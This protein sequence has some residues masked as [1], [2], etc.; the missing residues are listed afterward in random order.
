M[1]VCLINIFELINNPKN[2]EFQEGKMCVSNFV[3]TAK[4]MKPQILK[5]G[6]G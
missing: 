3:V 2:V 4:M 1:I 6:D 5:I